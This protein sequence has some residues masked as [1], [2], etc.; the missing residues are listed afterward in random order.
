MTDCLSPNEMLNHRR[1]QGLDGDS[2][3]ALKSLYAVCARWFDEFSI[4]C[5]AFSSAAIAGYQGE[6]AKILPGQRFPR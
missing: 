2:T 1:E 6:S 4:G 3:V 5:V